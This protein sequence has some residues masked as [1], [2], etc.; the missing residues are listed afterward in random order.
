MWPP[1]SN[2]DAPRGLVE[3]LVS[4]TH[5]LLSCKP[6][7]FQPST[8][9]KKHSQK[10]RERRTVPA[11]SRTPPDFFWAP[12]GSS[13]AGASALELSPARL[14]GGDLT[15]GREASREAHPVPPFLLHAWPHVGQGGLQPRFL[16]RVS[17]PSPRTAQPQT[18][19]KAQGARIGGC[20]LFL[21]LVK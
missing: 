17:I 12:F 14:P 20:F 15:G 11:D 6:P 7:I 9:S 21:S 18:P 13:L 16:S 3:P 1:F 2:R 5:H 4:V 19:H 8:I 10:L